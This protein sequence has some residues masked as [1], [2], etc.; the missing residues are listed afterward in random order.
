MNKDFETMMM[1]AGGLGAWM[2]GLI[3]NL[4]KKETIV[5]I[6]AGVFLTMLFIGIVELLRY[7]I[8]NIFFCIA[9]AFFVG[10]INLNF[11]RKLRCFIEDI[12]DILKQWFKNLL[13]VK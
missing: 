2:R 13:K 5:N 7:K 1:I 4:V 10:W 12:Y 11:T 9:I 8:E 6:I 3:E